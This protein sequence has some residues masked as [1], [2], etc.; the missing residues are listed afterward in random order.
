MSEK[1]RGIG[2]SRRRL[3]GGVLA[4]GAVAAGGGAGTWA[5]F[6]DTASSSASTVEAGTLDLT[7]SDGDEGFG[8][9]VSGSWTL[10]NAK[11]GD[12]VLADVSLQNAGSIE[13]DHVELGVSVTETEADGPTGANEADTMPSSAAGMAEQF[14]VTVMTYD[15]VNLLSNLADANGNG[16]VDLG[17]L[18]SGN[19]A[20]LDDLSPPPAANGG[21]ESLSMGLRWAHDV[22]FDTAVSGTNNDYQGDDL[23]VTVTMALHQDD[24]QDA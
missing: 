21:T 14:E 9:G 22:E 11:P 15:G 20:V 6:Q 7:V 24:S 17:D 10:S 18:V 5:Y 13:A 4:T 3:L 23:T 16:I 19:D 8:D 1:P 12:S 2:V